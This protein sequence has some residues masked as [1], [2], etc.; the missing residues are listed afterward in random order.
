MYKAIAKGKMPNKYGL[1]MVTN[2]YCPACLDLYTFLEAKKIARIVT[3]NPTKSYNRIS[4]MTTSC[5][6]STLS[7][8]TNKLPINKNTPTIKGVRS[9]IP[10][11]DSGLCL[12]DFKGPFRTAKSSSDNLSN[13]FL[14]ITPRSFYKGNCLYF[15]SS[16]FAYFHIFFLF[17]PKNVARE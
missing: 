8:N 14:I 6:G 16:Y 10:P 2:K 9:K 1:I 5:A 17:F 3:T 11:N 12:P 15:L 4:I 7:M 13:L